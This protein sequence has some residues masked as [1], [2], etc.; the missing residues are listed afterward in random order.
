[1][2]RFQ[3]KERPKNVVE[4]LEPGFFC[5]FERKDGRA[6]PYFKVNVKNYNSFNRHLELQQAKEL[7]S[8]T[9]VTWGWTEHV[10]SEN[11]VAIKVQFTE[12]TKTEISIVFDDLNEYC[13]YI[14]VMQLANCFCLVV[15]DKSLVEAVRY[16]E[17]GLI[18]DIP[19]DAT[20]PKWSKIYEQ[21]M[22]KRKRDEGMRR[23][24]AKKEAKKFIK[25]F[26]SLW[27]KNEL[28]KHYATTKVR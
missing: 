23:G 12:P 27:V 3:E 19:D 6:I 9:V 20:F 8:D 24:V 11:N 14:E 21:T 13:E 2:F 7:P 28:S 25:R 22:I 26:K 15:S 18:I 1:M 17:P 4:I 16:G 5:G 10:F